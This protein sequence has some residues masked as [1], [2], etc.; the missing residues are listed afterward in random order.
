MP[1]L[2]ELKFRSW[3]PIG[4]VVRRVESWNSRTLPVGSPEADC[5]RD[6]HRHLVAELPGLRVDRQ[7]PHGRVRADLLVDGRVALELKVGLC[8]NAE[9][10]RL[11]AQLD[12]YRRWGVALVVVLV[13]VGSEQLRRDIEQILERDWDWGAGRLIAMP[14]G[15]SV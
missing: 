6:L 2:S 5:E 11:V 4:T 12:G 1:N 10:N 13:G 14:L 9:Y 8:S 7:F 15:E 3:D